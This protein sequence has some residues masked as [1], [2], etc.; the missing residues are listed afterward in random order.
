[1]GIT[2]WSP[3]SLTK[4]SDMN[5]IILLLGFVFLVCLTV[6]TENDESLS[7]SSLSVRTA[8]EADPK[9]RKM[10]KMKKRGNKGGRRMRKG[11]RR[12]KKR[13]N[14]GKKKGRKGS[15][16]KPRSNGRGKKRAG[17]RRKT[18]G[19]YYGFPY[20]GNG[21]AVA[22][23]TQSSDTGCLASV[24]KYMRQIAD[25]VNNFENQR[26][27]AERQSGLMVKKNSKNKTEP[28][29]TVAALILAAGGGNKSNMVCANKTG[30]TEAKTLTSLYTSLSNCSVS[31]NASCGNHTYTSL[32]KTLVDSCMT[33][34]KDFSEA[35]KECSDKDCECWNG[36]M[37]KEMSGKLSTCKAIKEPTTKITTQKN[38]CSA[39]FR[40]CKVAEDK[41][42][43]A[44][45]ACM[46]SPV[47]SAKL[48]QKAKTLK[49]N[50]DAANAALKVVKALSGSRRQRAIATT[51][52]E[53][54]TKSNA[55]TKVITASASDASIA[56]LSLE[57]SSVSTSVMICDDAQKTELG[58]A[59]SSMETAVKTITAALA[60]VMAELE[61]LTGSTPS[62]ADLTATTA[63]AT[64]APS[65]RREMLLKNYV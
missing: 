28:F 23:G 32:N 13:G 65:A 59:A 45:A 11:N 61:A 12:S 19:R 57:I 4:D 40:L 58:V 53:V 20:Q 64:K 44:L 16:N 21:S 31:V 17:R 7:D 14:G 46:T 54:L 26:K 62:T 42:V 8:R 52:A 36:K 60:S 5:K 24:I 22:N 35:V 3:K 18:S 39:A 30:T 25:I 33:L 27:R 51:C 48:L 38:A 10:K 6:A 15:K 47:S 29:A 63:T 9:R 49:A 41:T 2:V 43:P 56:T 37:L 50:E 55:L 34:T 1:M